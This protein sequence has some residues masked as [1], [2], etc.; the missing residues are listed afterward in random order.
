MFHVSIFRQ[1]EK[2]FPIL[3][4]VSCPTDFV[5]FDNL[6]YYVDSSFVDNIR[7]GE[8]VCSNKY[9]NSTLVKFNSHEWGNVNTTRFIGRTFDDILL[10]FFYYQLEKKLIIETKNN[11]NKKHWLR[12]LIGHK[13][14][15]NE[16]ILRYFNRLSGAFT[17]S[18]QCNHG[19]HPV[20]QCQPISIN[21]TRNYSVEIDFKTESSTTTEIT[22]PI[23]SN[24]TAV[25]ICDNCTNLIS[26]EDLL[27]NETNTEYIYDHNKTS[28]EKKSRSSYRL[29]LML[30]TG[31]LLALAILLI[32]TVFLIR[33]VRRSHGSYSTRNSSRI[34]SFNRRK[35]SSTTTSSNDQS[36]VP[37]VL[38]TRLKSPPPSV[39]IDGNMTH[40]FDNLMTNDDNIQLLSQLRNQTNVHENIITEDEEEPLYA[41]L[42]LPNEK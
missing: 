28:I 30:A 39:I 14:D 9:S 32:G 16:C 35:R 12:L 2:Q 33:Y 7:H 36:N 3:D 13:N 24:E 18:H 6:C 31:P 34:G 40:P 20:C 37:A 23:L 11:T 41:T 22:L 8:Q 21:Q 19:G 1:N 29:L 27:N 17:A 5:L 25:P 10:E 4:N 42:K 38:Y 26:D 15:P